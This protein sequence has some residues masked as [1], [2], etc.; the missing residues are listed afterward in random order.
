MASL[1]FLGDHAALMTITIC[2]LLFGLALL[3]VFL[4]AVLKKDEVRASGTYGHFGF[5][6]E[7]KDK[8]HKKL[9]S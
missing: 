4:V 1:D 8:N 9:G 2:A 5:S 3:A 7:A 6:L